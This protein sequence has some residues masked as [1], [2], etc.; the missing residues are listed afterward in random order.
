MNTEVDGMICEYYVF[1]FFLFK[2]LYEK[3]KIMALVDP[4]HNV[5]NLR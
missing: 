5:K 1:Q 4:N 2:C 3:S